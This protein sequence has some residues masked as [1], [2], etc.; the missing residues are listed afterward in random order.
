MSWTCWRAAR[1]HILKMRRVKSR[2]SHLQSYYNCTPSVL[3][4][5]LIVWD[6]TR[7]IFRINRTR[8][9]CTR[10]LADRFFGKT[11]DPRRRRVSG[12]RY[13]EPRKTQ[14]CTYT[15]N[16]KNI[17]RLIYICTQW[18]N[19][20]LARFYSQFTCLLRSPPPPSSLLSLDL[21]AKKTFAARSTRGREYRS[22]SLLQD[23][24]RDNGDVPRPARIHGRNAG[25]KWYRYSKYRRRTPGH[26]RRGRFDR[27]RP[28]RVPCDVDDVWRFGTMLRKIC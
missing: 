28:P 10:T 8:A 15:F 17:A 21:H 24:Y 13:G 2:E 4:F 11:W 3:P 12:I 26:L 20:I 25:K 1:V 14:H 6:L 7:I 19:I 27:D 23:L 16:K 5:G 22:E 9:A 18:R